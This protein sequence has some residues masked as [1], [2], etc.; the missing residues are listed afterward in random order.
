MFQN[1]INDMNGEML[2]YFRGNR[3]H[4]LQTYLKIVRYFSLDPAVIGAFSLSI[5]VAN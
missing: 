2:A 1:S 3:V 5:H 4:N